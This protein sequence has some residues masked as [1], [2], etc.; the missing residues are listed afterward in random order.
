L[1]PLLSDSCRA[2]SGVGFFFASDADFFLSGHY[3]FFLI[4]K[5]FSDFLKKSGKKP[6]KKEK[7]IVRTRKNRSKKKPEKARQESD[8]SGNKSVENFFACGKPVENSCF[9][10]LTK[11]KPLI[12]FGKILGT[13]KVLTF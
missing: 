12:R 8:R 4:R 5:I 3:F 13:E 7:K 6:E 9:T 1:F 2:F 10:I 11:K